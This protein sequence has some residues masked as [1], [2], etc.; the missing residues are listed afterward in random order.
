MSDEETDDP[1][2]LA[3]LVTADEAKVLIAEA[4][5]TVERIDE[6]HQGE[7]VEDLDREARHLANSEQRLAATVIE[8]S[9]RIDKVI[10]ILDEP[11]TPTNEITLG[12]HWA[13]TDLKRIRVAVT[14]GG[15]Q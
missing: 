15:E 11:F 9:E 8:L 1:K 13:V 10:A 3:P 2:V 5:S 14:Q 12:Q 6:A 4:S 7:W